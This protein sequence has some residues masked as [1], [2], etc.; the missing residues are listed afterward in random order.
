[1]GYTLK[2]FFTLHFL[3]PFIVLV[4][5]LRHLILLH[6][7]RSNSTFYGV[8]RKNFFTLFLIKDMLSWLLYFLVLM[9]LR[10]LLINLLGDVENYL[11]ANSLVTPL[12]IKPE[13]YFLF[14]YSILRCIPSKTVRVLALL[15][16]VLFPVTLIFS[17]F[18]SGNS[19]FT[20]FLFFFILLTIT[21]SIP[22]EE[23]YVVIAQI[24]SVGYFLSFIT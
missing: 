11:E 21:R 2:R 8:T 23:P 4:L 24:I 12:H 9:T 16:S 10:H 15:L 20:M 14:A 19:N 6:F 3:L 7:T 18:R 5:V 1:M 17:R 13:W 22:V